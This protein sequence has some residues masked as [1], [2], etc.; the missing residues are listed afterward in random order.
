MLALL[1]I[2]HELIFGGNLIGPK[3]VNLIPEAIV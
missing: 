1:W 3:S 2:L